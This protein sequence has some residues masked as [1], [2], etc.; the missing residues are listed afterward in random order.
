MANKKTFLRIRGDSGQ[1]R[2]ILLIGLIL[3]MLAFIPIG[4]QLYTLMV[5]DY[6]YYARLALQNQT[7]TTRVT[8]NRGT[9]Y[10]RNM[11]ILAASRSVENIY[12][13]PHELRQSKA[14]LD[15]VSSE[16]SRILSVEESEILKKAKNT[17]LRYQQIAAFV[18]EDTA[19]Q[20]RAF[21]NS[22]DISGIHI[23]PAF[24]RYYPCGTL[25]A[26]VLGFTN[27]SHTGVEGVE[28]AYN[29]FLQ[30]GVGRVITTKGNN[31]MDMPFSY[32]NFAAA[33]EGCSLVLTLD[34][35]VQT[36]L[37]KQMQAAIDRYD[38]QNGAF[39]MVMDVDTGE[40]LA[41]ATLGSYD[42]NQYL[43][44]YDEEEALRL[45][46]LRLSYLM[47][48]PESETYTDG[49]QTYLQQ[50]HDAQLKQWRNRCI[51]DGYEPGSTFKVL[52]MAAALDSG[53]I[54]LNT[55]FHCGGSE[56]IPGRSQLL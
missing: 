56:R 3:G 37:E 51:S 11:N 5:R 23:E 32:E 6:A 54:T 50:L 24:K 36:C 29:S 30:G 19:A 28:A 7:R 38:V 16:L 2:R 18:E 25:A 40:V 44:I 9:I 15:L 20:V 22:R 41:M 53:A 55:D 31:E 13:D 46:Q 17:R 21:V 39:G 42:P 4:L 27:I 1:Q 43:T 34:T 12:L 49:K 48:P 47:E 45:E 8:A 35:T 14:D 26:Q 33:P 52:T 10:D